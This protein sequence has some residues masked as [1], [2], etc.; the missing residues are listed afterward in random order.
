MATSV[1]IDSYKNYIKPIKNGN[2]APIMKATIGHA[3][4]GAALFAMY[5][6]AFGQQKP[7]EESPFLDKA[8]ANLWRGEF[9]GMFGEFI[10]PYDKPGLSSPL[11]EPVIIRNARIAGDEV[12]NWLQ[13]GK[14]LDDAVKDFTKKAV[15]GFGQLDKAWNKR[16]HPY[17]S[18]TK[19]LKVLERQ[20][21]KQM[22][23]E[24]IQQGKF[25]SQRTPFYWKLKEAIMFGKTDKEIAQAYYAAFNS[26]CSNFWPIALDNGPETRTTPMP[27][28]PIAVARA[29]IVSTLCIVCKII[30]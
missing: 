2:I 23:Y 29:H 20:W 12:L 8:M 1:T 18:N 16:K 10:S 21:E 19:R 22:G 5:E 26:I 13:Y 11:M 7:Q 24:Q 4:S 3:L 25:M 30:F 28:C 14:G 17:V 9:L 15:V 27:L 6:Y